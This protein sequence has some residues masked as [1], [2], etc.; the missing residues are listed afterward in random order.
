MT[1]LM[2]ARTMLLN[3][4]ILLG[5]LILAAAS[6]AVQAAPGADLTSWNTYRNEP[7]GFEVMHPANWRVRRTTGTGPESVLL[8]EVPKAGRPNLSIQFFLQRNINPRRL[9]LDE[10]FADQLKIVKAAPAPGAHHTIGGRPAIRMEA[11]GA[12]GARSSFFVSSNPTDMLTIFT[13][14]SGAA[15][16]DETV[17]QILSTI[18]FTK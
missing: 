4:A 17:E 14:G 5:A 18:Q 16:L 1:H 7:M 2:T 6:A 10:W 11:S 9:S 13:S 3:R 15:A 12:F 8:T